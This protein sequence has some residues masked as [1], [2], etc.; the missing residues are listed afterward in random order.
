MIEYAIEW[1]L[2]NGPLDVQTTFNHLNTGRVWYSN[3]HRTHYYLA[4]G[5][6][7]KQFC[8]YFIFR[9]ESEQ[10]Q[11]SNQS[12]RYLNSESQNDS[13]PPNVNE[14]SILLNKSRYNIL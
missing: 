11:F 4:F 2:V 3:P 6:I 8:F 13:T 7:L 12:P 9:D 10:S 5:N 1:Y 14:V